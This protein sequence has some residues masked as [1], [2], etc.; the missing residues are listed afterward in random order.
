MLDISA[1][2]I[3]TGALTLARRNLA[4][5]ETLWEL[6]DTP[7]PAQ[8]DALRG[9]IGWGPLA[10]AFNK[11][12]TLKGSWIDI[13][14]RLLEGLSASAELAARQAVDVAF[15]TTP[16]LTRAIWRVAEALGFSGGL[17]LEPGCGAGAFMGEVPP[18]LPVEW[19]GVEKDETSARIA[20]LLHPHAR[21]ISAPLEQTSLRPGTFDLVVGNV[22]F[23]KDAPYDPTW[24]DDLPQLNLHNYFM[25]RAIQATRPGGLIML[26]TSRYTMDS[27]DGFA[28]KLFN[29]DAAFV[30]A[31][32]LPTGAFGENGTGAVADLVVLRRRTG[33]EGAADEW[34][35]ADVVD[36]LHTT[37][38]T[39]WRRHPEMVLGRMEAKAAAQYG[40][41]IEIVAPE[42]ADL[43]ELIAGAGTRLVAE[44]AER[45]LFWEPREDPAAA[46][47]VL[48]NDGAMEGRF[49]VL[50]DGTVTQVINGEP[51]IRERATDELKELIFLRDAAEALFAAEADPDRPDAEITPVREHAR[52]L[53]NTYVGRYGPLNRNTLVERAAKPDDILE[54]RAVPSAKPVADLSEFDPALCDAEGRRWVTLTRQR[55]PMGGFRSD[56]GFVTVL[57]IETW[58]DDTLFAAP[59]PILLRRVN[60]RPVRKAFADD[61]AEAIALCLDELGRFSLP[62]VAEL[63]QVPEADAAGQVAG[64]AFHDPGS[65]EW[66]TAEEYLSGDVRVKLREARAAAEADP[67]RWGG[68][69]RALEE[70]QPKDLGPAEIRARLGAPWVP[71]SD[72]QAFIAETFDTNP[73]YIDIHHDPVTATWDVKSYAVS[74]TRAATR[75]YG[76]DRVHAVRLIELALNGSGPVVY[77]THKVNG[78]KIRVRNHEA[79]Q[80]AEERQKALQD[81]FG[82]WIWSDPER[83]ARLCRYYNDTYNAH[84]ARTFDGSYLTF[85]GLLAGFNP[86]QHQKDMVARMIA[87]PSVLCGHTVGGGK[88]AIMAMGSQTLR[89]LGL[90]KKPLIT[91]P[92][93]LLEQTAAELRRLYPAARVLMVTKD[94][95]SKER[96]AMFAARVAAVDWDFV[97]MTHQQFGAIP[98]S[99]DLEAEYLADTIDQLTEAVMVDGVAKSPTAKHIAGMIRKL[100]KRYK[101]LRAST[102]EPVGGLYFDRLGIDYVLADEAHAF[103]NLFAPS[104]MEGFSFPASKRAEHLF[105]VTTWLRRRNRHGRALAMFTGTPV[106]NSLVEV[107]TLMRYLSPETLTRLGLAAFEAFVGQHVIFE[108]KIEV[109][110]D[111][112]GF[113]LHR[114]PAR[115]TN[116]P[117]LRLGLSQFADIRTRRHLKLGGPRI[118]NRLVREFEPAPEHADVTGKLVWR[119][120]QIRRGRVK[121]KEDNMLSVCS[122]GRKAALWLPL[123]GVKPSA[124]GKIEGLVAEVARIYHANKDRAF[125]DLKAGLLFGDTLGALQVV[126]CDLGTPNPER[127]DQVYGEVRRQLIEAGVPDRMIRLI[128]DARTPLELKRLL[129][130][131]RDGEVAVLLTSTEKAG[132]GVNIQDRLVAIHHLDAPWRPSDVEQRDGRGERPGNLC[133]LLEIIRYVT[134]RSFDAYMWQTLVRKAEF[135]WQVLCGDTDVRE[136]DDISS[137]QVLD[138]HQIL[139]VTTGQEILLE[140]AQVE[141]EVARLQN[142]AAEHS[143]NR[144]ST[145]SEIAYNQAQAE[146]FRTSATLLDDIV[147]ASADADRVYRR[148][149]GAIVEDEEEAAK[150][151]GEAART[152]RAQKREVS[153][154]RWRGVNVQFSVLWWKNKAEMHVKLSHPRRFNRHYDVVVTAMSYRKGNEA[155]LLHVLDSVLDRAA[156][157]AAFMRE[158][159]A[160]SAARVEEIKPNL[161]GE[162]AEA[163]ALEAALARREEIRLEIAAQAD[164]VPGNGEDVDA[165]PVAA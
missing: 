95:L 47:V 161:E 149:D 137:D 8:L 80:V 109:A 85:P 146:E 1:P 62:R 107:W 79:T 103:K 159:A 141:A 25:W 58:D 16:T 10:T 24:P 126:F 102:D 152:S 86:Y 39:Y 57:A 64:L 112:S 101:E 110:P 83:T 154:G 124:P 38:N 37:I 88:T 139:A 151:L 131:C 9:W 108:S 129:Q 130:Q 142:L 70:V 59:A 27:G 87:T 78:K 2:E 93:H 127:G 73:A 36:E 82:Q 55:P 99:P 30:G 128:H 50:S 145:E 90:I 11:R 65:R 94:D 111:G 134:Q 14:D 138:Y 162:F 5:L 4:A 71:A 132:T 158:N 35:N 106:S 164:A 163:A 140:L 157:R 45:G 97:V 81:K 148:V 19:F 3:P 147:Q 67:A 68:N 32:R 96:R 41:T 63:L 51:V 13:Q 66:V 105:L 150:A 123:V 33:S 61:P 122:D 43:T 40:H 12:Q 77:D 15:Y 76:T 75:T 56:P 153:A 20:Q 7:T 49:E 135:I 74:Q 98:V 21:I 42:G 143:R 48:D 165:A 69:V 121:P 156:E 46:N 53:Y 23:A 160:Y 26:L 84:R 104:A 17:T 100:D 92:N 115:F 28:R 72:V 6:D 29:Q 60:S 118:V 113:R 116:V 18:G 44:A 34:L 114:R 119:A 120:D 52:H 22:P 31:I 133:D 155:D 117:E 91:V 136:V 144:R 125:P 89:R 54:G